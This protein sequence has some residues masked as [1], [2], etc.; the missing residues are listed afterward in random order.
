MHNER[1][2]TEHN[3]SKRSRSV[4][5]S[6]KFSDLNGHQGYQRSISSF[7]PRI[8]HGPHAIVPSLDDLGFHTSSEEEGEENHDLHIQNQPQHMRLRRPLSGGAAR[9]GVQSRMSS[10]SSVVRSRSS[11]AIRR[12]RATTSSDLRKSSPDVRH[13]MSRAYADRHNLQ[14]DSDDS[15]CQVATWRTEQQLTKRKL[16]PHGLNFT[17]ADDDDDDETQKEHKSLSLSKKSRQSNITKPRSITSISSNN[18]SK[19]S[20]TDG[21]LRHNTQGKEESFIYSVHQVQNMI[22]FMKGNERMKDKQQNVNLEHAA[23]FQDSAKHSHSR[24]H[25]RWYRHSKSHFDVDDIPPGVFAFDMPMTERNKLRLSSKEFVNHVLRDLKNNPSGMVKLQNAISS[26]QAKQR[27]TVNQNACSSDFNAIERNMHIPADLAEQRLQNIRQQ[28]EE[29]ENRMILANSRRA[30]V[31]KAYM[32]H[33]VN[34]S[35]RE[36]IKRERAD[37]KRQEIV[38]KT[39]L[40]EKKLKWS[41]FIVFFN[42]FQRISQHLLHE[43]EIRKEEEQ[44]EKMKHFIQS[45]LMPFIWKRRREKWMEAWDVFQKHWVFY[46]L[47]IDIK[48]KK[49]AIEIIKSFLND[50]RTSL[51]FVRQTH[52]F[53]NRVIAI[54]RRRKEV[55]ERKEERLALNLLQYCIVE[56]KLLRGEPL[57]QSASDRIA[58]PLFN[59]KIGR[60][61]YKR[62]SQARPP[63]AT[64]VL[65]RRQ[66]ANSR[67]DEQQDSEDHSN[68]DTARSSSRNSSRQSLVTKLDPMFRIEDELGVLMELENEQVDPWH[69]RNA[70]IVYHVP[71]EFKRRAMMVDIERRL[72]QHRLAQAQYER[73]LH[74]FRAKAHRMSYIHRAKDILGGSFEG[75]K[76]HKENNIEIK[77]TSSHGK[78]DLT[79]Y[80]SYVDDKGETHYRPVEP[81]LHVFLSEQEIAPLVIEG[82]KYVQRLETRALEDITLKFQGDDNEIEM[83]RSRFTQRH[84]ESVEEC[85]SFIGK[86]I[87][88]LFRDHEPYLRVSMEQVNIVNIEINERRRTLAESLFKQRALEDSAAAAA[89]ANATRLMGFGNVSQKDVTKGKEVRKRKK[90]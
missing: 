68:F 66:E 58:T 24:G 28:A 60:F 2:G 85:F 15:F 10:S 50:T 17:R 43:R 72:E 19:N 3:Q 61:Q 49:E 22:E 70:L 87:P 75:A 8:S 38:T 7:L 78:Q 11:L 51:Q 71:Y 5:I 40:A 84:N 21:S 81:L 56:A 67:I 69:N 64:S 31:L 65:S 37:K 42:R 80:S 82:F 52:M 13:T 76:S 59:P 73:M 1:Q 16:K 48:I 29:R 14:D 63:S 6:A 4:N 83:E 33:K 77:T 27:D 18:S 23:R 74:S 88:F 79:D 32:Q 36:R 62:R 53:R 41:F 25:M 46:R 20:I 44:H 45:K 34:I 57:L 39:M 26:Y 90:K 47:W 9:Q 30:E 86:R 35:E 12:G 55:F 89:T 54:Q